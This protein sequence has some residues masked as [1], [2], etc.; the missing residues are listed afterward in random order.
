[1]LRAIGS[2][3]VVLLVLGACSGESFERIQGEE[4]TLPRGEWVS[5]PTSGMEVSMKYTKELEGDRA[6]FDCK[7]GEFS[8]MMEA[9]VGEVEKL[10]VSVTTYDVYERPE[11]TSFRGTVFQLVEVEEDQV[12]ILAAPAE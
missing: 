1:M 4:L 6:S 10:G 11:A 5:L 12:V 3:A 2:A 8:D 7:M 9:G